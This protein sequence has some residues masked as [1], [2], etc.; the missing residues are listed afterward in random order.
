MEIKVPHLGESVSEAVVCALLKEDGAFVKADDE[1]LEIETEKVNQIIYAPSSGRL[2]YLVKIGDQLEP[3][4]AVAELFD[5]QE[6]GVDDTTLLK[7]QEKVLENIQD[8]DIFQAPKDGSFDSEN[9]SV[10]SQ[11]SLFEEKA[12]D[13]EQVFD[14][15]RDLGQ[16]FF[17]SD[18]ESKALV[19]GHDLVHDENPQEEDAQEEEPE[20]LEDDQSLD[21]DLED[22]LQDSSKQE[23]DQ[24]KQSPQ[25]EILE[26]SHDL[27]SQEADAFEVQVFEAPAPLAPARNN[28][29]TK[30]F[31]PRPRKEKPSGRQ[32]KSD[33][34]ARL[35]QEV[36]AS[37]DSK[38]KLLILP[39]VDPLAV[40]PRKEYAVDKKPLSKIRKVIQRRM[41]EA[42]N[43]SASLTTFNELD[44]S[45]IKNLRASFG[46]AFKEKYGI[47][48]GFMSFFVKAV[49]HACKDFPQVL[50]YID[51][52]QLVSRHDR[53]IAIAISTPKGLVVPVI[54][55]CER[56]SFA[57]IEVALA[58]F[59]KKAIDGRLKL[60]ELQ[61]GG[62]TITNG[63]VFGSLF[64]TPLLN[65]PQTAI[66]GMHK[67]QDRVIAENEQ[68]L[69]RPM[70][71][72][73]LTYNHAV[74]DGKEAVGFL[75]KIKEFIETPFNDPE[76][77]LLL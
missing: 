58:H 25:E 67:I 4:D 17:S 13:Q 23:L 46:Q 53:D 6:Q 3:G 2:K 48:L 70:M 8:E 34:L 52:D 42:K 51:Q 33:Y 62:F 20:S 30:D 59:Q 12:L 10:F 63:G 29:H 16:N 15:N 66:L 26:D 76:Q 77:E 40:E 36:N 56:L 11:K 24:L 21:D 73:A 7:R 18:K 43:N 27:E 37:L 69:I 35:G 55:N 64:S 68:M 38:D 39:K 5:K 54:R 9:L 28:L 60:E 61:G 47:K 45:H 71:Y 49:I 1:L 22:D 57:Q 31:E 41:V 14:E 50:S 32:S 75:M 72:L 74:I 65:P 44:M 19:T